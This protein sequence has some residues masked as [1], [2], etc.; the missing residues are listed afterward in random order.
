MTNSP[1]LQERVRERAREGAATEHM[2]V[3]VAAQLAGE[4]ESG[5][6]RASEVGGGSRSGAPAL[7]RA[8]A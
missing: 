2:R 6:V 5:V 4:A 3:A 1:A 8:R 7:R